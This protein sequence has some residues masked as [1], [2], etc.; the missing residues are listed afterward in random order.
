MKKTYI[1]SLTMLLGLCTIA[2]ENTGGKDKSSDPKGFGIKAGVNFANVTNASQVNAGNTTGF[3]IGAFFQ[4]SSKGLFGYRSEILYSKQGYDFASSTATGAVKLDYIL[5][6]Q[7]MTINI[8][9]FLEIHAGFQMAFLLNASADS[10]KPASGSD[11][12]A[13]IMEYYNRFDYGFCGG[14]EIKPIR[15][16][17]IGARYNIS[18]NSLYKDPYSVSGTTPPFIPDISDLNVRNNVF[19]LY[20]GLKF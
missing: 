11:P 16:L 19:Q 20:A 4:P 3:L 12:Y 18:L 1:L 9:R 14:V 5:L 8:T 7:L 13:D 15:R 10:S 6:P 2:Q 17:F